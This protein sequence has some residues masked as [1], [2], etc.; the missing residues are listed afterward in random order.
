MGPIPFLLL[1]SNHICFRTDDMSSLNQNL[2]NS[3]KKLV[4][5]T[6]VKHLKLGTQ[7]LLPKSALVSFSHMKHG[8]KIVFSTMLIISIKKLLVISTVVGGRRTHPGSVFS[9]D[10]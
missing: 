4:C 6:S 5:S 1:P 10:L 9:K 3:G 2:P 8:V 7:V